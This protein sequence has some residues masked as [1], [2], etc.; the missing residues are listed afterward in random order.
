MSLKVYFHF[1]KTMQKH[2]QLWLVLNCV[3][4]LM[5]AQ[6]I[7][8]FIQQMFEHLCMSWCGGGGWCD[9]WE[10]AAT[11]LTMVLVL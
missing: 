10:V 2:D 7:C 11:V 8:K 1:L 5:K 3:I 6:F 9:G 4:M